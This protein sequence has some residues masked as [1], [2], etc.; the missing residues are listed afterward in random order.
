MS[1]LLDAVVLAQSGLL[2]LTQHRATVASLRR[3]SDTANERQLT[4]ALKIGKGI[5]QT[6]GIVHLADFVT[7]IVETQGTSPSLVWAAKLAAA[8]ISFQSAQL[9]NSKTDVVT[10]SCAVSSALSIA[11]LAM[12]SNHVYTH[13]A[14][15]ALDLAA[16]A[17][18]FKRFV[19][20]RR[21]P[22]IALTEDLR[23]LALSYEKD[24]AAE[25]GHAV[26]EKPIVFKGYAVM[27]TE[28]WKDFKLIDFTV[29]L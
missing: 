28:T 15:A 17:A 13:A 11:R 25:D 21:G 8:L 3:D 12:G 7:H 16:L 1:A 18:L 2:S 10:A 22:S 4:P 23:Q 14:A 26:D 9:V 29:H 19:D 27:S 5:F 24:L 20:A 6:A